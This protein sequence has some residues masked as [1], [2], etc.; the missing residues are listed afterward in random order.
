MSLP[1]FNAAMGF[2]ERSPECLNEF[3]A[4]MAIGRMRVRFRIYAIYKMFIPLQVDA[5][6]FLRF[7]QRFILGGEPKLL[8]AGAAQARRERRA[9]YQG[10]FAFHVQHHS[11]SQKRPTL[12]RLT[13]YLVHHCHMS[14][15]AGLPRKWL[16]YRFS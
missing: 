13:A 14:G 4:L 15:T 6:S 9:T 11:A 16:V 7:P 8:H 5:P 1:L 3:I 2:L 12:C 10:K